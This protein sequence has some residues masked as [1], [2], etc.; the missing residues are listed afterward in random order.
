[1][2]AKEF[3]LKYEDLLVR[4]LVDLGFRTHGQSLALTRNET[5][6]ALLRF[7]TKFS[8]L[9]QS[10]HFLLCVR[11]SFLRTLGKEPAKKFLRSASEYPFKLPVS[12]L[13]PDQLRAWRYEPINLGPRTYDTIEFGKLSGAIPILVDMRQRII[14]LGLRWMEYLTPA[15]ALAQIR[16]YGED[17]YCERIW[18][19]DYG[20]FLDAKAGAQSTPT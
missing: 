19:E 8:A 16:K 12:R 3:K 10:T 5:E 2:D 18:I 4:P 15:E 1:V 13:S 14:D 20:T 9:T 11:H 7:Q 17:A 6:L